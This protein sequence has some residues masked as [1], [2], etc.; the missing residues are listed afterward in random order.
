MSAKRLYAD[1]AALPCTCG[2]GDP[3]EVWDLMGGAFWCQC[4]T[5]GNTVEGDTEDEAR[6]A[7]NL[8]ARA[9]LARGVAA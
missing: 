6:A 4:A 5:C 2:G 8:E 1:L 7:W 9:I 3:V